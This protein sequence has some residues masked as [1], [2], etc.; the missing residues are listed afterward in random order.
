MVD[1]AITVV[2]NLT[3]DP[4]IRYTQTGTA[5]ALLGV[6]VNRRWVNRRTQ[7]TEES[8]SFF[9]VICWDTLAQNV[10]DSLSKGQRVIVSGR[11]E[12]RN[13]DTPDG[14]KRNVVEIVAQEIAPS[15]RWCTAAVTPNPRN[16]PDDGGYDQQRGGG[17]HGD[18]SGGYAG[19]AGGSSSGAQQGEEPF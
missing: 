14:E 2:G 11:L 7:E 17:S 16:R 8:V 1:N 3:R 5:R 9:N 10:A 6:A 19:A 18:S 13:W 15:L 4:E 12:Q